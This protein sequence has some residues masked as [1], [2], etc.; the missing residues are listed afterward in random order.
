MKIKFM[1][2]ALEQIP[3]PSK[4]RR[5]VYDTEES[6]LA[7]RITAN[8]SRTFYV[9][10][11]QGGKMIWVRLG[12]LNEM[13][14][15]AARKAAKNARS[16]IMSGANPNQIKQEMRDAATLADLWTDYLESH[17]E[18]H[19]RPSS[20]RA[21]EQLY[22][23]HLKPWAAKRLTDITAIA[24]DLLKTRIAKTSTTGANRTLALLSIM[25]R[26]RGFHFGLDRNWTPTAGLT[27]YKE[28]SRNRVLSAEEL[29]A[30]LASIKA[31]AN[32]DMRDYFLMLLYTGARR[33]TVAAMRWEDVSTQRATWKIPGEKTKNGSQLV[34]ALVP[35]AMA[36]LKSRSDAS[37][38]V[39]PVNRVTQGALDQV[40]AMHA[41]GK[42][43]REIAAAAGVSQ[44]QVVRM[45]K[46]DF[47]AG[48]AGPL[49]GVAKAWKRILAAAKVTE[50]TTIHDLRRTFCSQLVN[51]GVPLT[52]TADAMGHKTLATTQKHYAHADQSKVRAAVAAAVKAMEAMP[53]PKVGA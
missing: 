43:T 7:V 41:E 18:Q 8:N 40:K 44:T 24:V 46:P 19:N 6:G 48:E 17:A 38:F 23:Q 1:K 32:A 9:V 39:F 4:G 11:R 52:H 53:V 42:S 14:I 47:K 26:K 34:V 22:R 13:T 37:P 20:I 10:K 50:R 3:T 25:F 33:S 45:L 27:R 16:D 31:E 15:D 2:T 35:E 28:K 21:N 29:P 36:I 49:N 5:V 51:A 12:S 30:V